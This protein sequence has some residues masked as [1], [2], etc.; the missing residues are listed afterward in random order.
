MEDLHAKPSGKPELS[1]GLL[2]LDQF[3]LAAFS[4][5]VRAGPVLTPI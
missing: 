1:V 3:T 4:G 2:L 5:F